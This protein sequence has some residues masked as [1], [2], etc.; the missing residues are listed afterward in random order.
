LAETSS[1]VALVAAGD[2]PDLQVAVLLELLRVASTSTAG[3]VAL[4]DAGALR[5]LPAVLRVERAREVA[6]DLLS[7]EERSLRVLLDELGVVAI[8]ERS[9]LALDPG[10]RSLFDIDAPEDL[11]L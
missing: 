5:P 4:L 3:A 6:V 2:M 1:E 9:W 8:D 7:R 10:R 11:E